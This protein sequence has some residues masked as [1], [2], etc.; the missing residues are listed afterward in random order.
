MS[1]YGESS[2]RMFNAVYWRIDG[3]Y[4]KRKQAMC[5]GKDYD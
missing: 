1:G 2:V 5:R 3:E 4:E